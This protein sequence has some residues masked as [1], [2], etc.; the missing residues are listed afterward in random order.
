MAVSLSKGQKVDLTKTNPGLTNVVVGLGWDTNKYDGGN[1]F[2]LDSSVFLLGDNGKVTTESDFVFYNNPKG[3]NGSVEHTG[4][5]RT[6]AGDGDDEQVKINLTSIPANIQ[7]IA[8]TITIHE[9]DTRNQNFGQVSNAYAR[10][11]NESGGEELI[12][13][14]L[15]EDFSIETALVVGELYKSDRSHVVL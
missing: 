11:F 7:R 3:G 13:Y 15:G 9:A 12:R 8:F 14:D 6:G 2:D 4:D 5:N 10:I 1:D